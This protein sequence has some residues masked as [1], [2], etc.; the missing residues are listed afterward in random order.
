MKE[1][2]VLFTHERAYILQTYNNLGHKKSWMIYSHFPAELFAIISSYLF[3]EYLNKIEYGQYNQ[4]ITE[5]NSQG[6]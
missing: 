6:F 1:I 4:L 3:K 5:F 2:F